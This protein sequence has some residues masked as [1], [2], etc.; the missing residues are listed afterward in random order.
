MKH[1]PKKNSKKIESLSEAQ[2]TWRVFNLEHTHTFLAVV[3]VLY[4][5]T[6]Q[7]FHSTKQQDQHTAR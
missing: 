3:L 6:S 5:Q 7:D 1:Y 4:L 2:K